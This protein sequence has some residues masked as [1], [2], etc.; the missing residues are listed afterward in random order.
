MAQ[1]DT[2]NAYTIKN[3]R[4]TTIATIFEDQTNRTATSLVLHGRGAY[5]YGKTRNENIVF[6]LENF[7]NST[8]PKNPLDGQLW[9]KD[10]DQFY[11]YDSVAGS[12]AWQPLVPQ[13]TGIGFYVTAGDGL[14]GGGLPSG[15][16]LS[17]TISIGVG[18][19]LSLGSPYIA[20]GGSP[21]PNALSVKEREV[22]HDDLSGFVANEHIDHSTVS[23]NAGDGLTGGGDLTVSRT[24]NV[25][26]GKGIIVNANDVAINS[27]YVMLTTGNQD[28]KGIKSFTGQI[29]AYASAS[30]AAPSYSFEGDSNTGIYH[31]AS[32]SN[33]ISFSTGATQ[34]F[35]IQSTGVLRS[36]NS[37]YESLLLIDDDIPNKKY[38]DDNVGSIS[39]PTATTFV[40][41][42]YISG[43][44]TNT[45]YLVSVYGQTRNAGTGSHTLQSITLRRGSTTTGSGTFVAQ[46][47]STSINWP[48][49]AFTT[50]CS[51]ICNTSSST[52]INATTEDAD[53]RASLYMLAV[54]LD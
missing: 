29:R 15:S 37:S 9:W 18:R 23:V 44:S 7:A 22:R 30:A 34:R 20:A 32:R 10:N 40:G 12:P 46:T 13:S 41:T 39:T 50:G 26:A 17:V 54:Q 19:G 3:T 33:E 49:G 25:G 36:L 14:L 8:A 38:V 43:L 45:T 51:F 24:L 6:R 35:R 31:Q 1:F 53:N 28:V 27:S 11:A 47:T 52:S 5:P 21:N 16:P 2:R 4:G 48:D 42:S